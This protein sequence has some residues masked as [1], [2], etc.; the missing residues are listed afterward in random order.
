[1]TNMADRPNPTHPDQSL[2]LY[3]GRT[4]FVPAGE[5]ISCC[6]HI[7]VFYIVQDGVIAL[8]PMDDRRPISFFLASSGHTFG[9]DAAISNEPRYY[10]ALA[11]TDSTITP[12]YLKHHFYKDVGLMVW[13]T[14][15]IAQRIKMR[16]DDMEALDHG[17]TVAIARALLK[18]RKTPIPFNTLR[19]RDIAEVAGVSRE[20]VA[21]IMAVLEKQ[22]IIKRTKPTNRPG[23]AVENWEAIIQLA[24]GIE[25]ESE[26]PPLIGADQ[27][28]LARFFLENKALFSIENS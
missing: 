11:L 10:R 23:I 28:S 20:S 18:I 2:M 19:Q 16:M 26:D 14:Q 27:D 9:E 6:D 5:Q 24:N 7:R 8:R 15:R 3:R 1:M 17:T 25:W 21:R 4:L 12:Y 22:K 13:L